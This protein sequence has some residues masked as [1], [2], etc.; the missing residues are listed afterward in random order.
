[1]SVAKHIKELP[2]AISHARLFDSSIVVEQYITGKEVSIVALRDFREKQIYTTIP[3]EIGEY[4]DPE[5]KKE[6]N[7]SS[8]YHHDYVAKTAGTRN[9]RPATL[10][11]VSEKNTLETTIIHIMKDMNL[12]T[13][14]FDFVVHPKRGVYL[15][16]V[17]TSV[18]AYPDSVAEIALKNSGITAQEYL[19]YLI[20]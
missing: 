2:D 7:I 15:L 12:R 10:L 18:K 6:M 17:N 3:L 19:R 20:G 1:V 11:S 14:V 4:K 13:A 8:T 16:E 5:M 9:Y